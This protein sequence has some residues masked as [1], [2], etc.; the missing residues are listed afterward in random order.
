MLFRSSNN[1]SN[2]LTYY[3][4]NPSYYKEKS[5]NTVDHH[6]LRSVKLPSLIQNIKKNGAI[7][8][9]EPLSYRY[10]DELSDLVGNVDRILNGKSNHN[11][12]NHECIQVMLNIIKGDTTLHDCNKEMQ[13]KIDHAYK[14][15]KKVDE[16]ATNLKQS[17]KEKL[18]SEFHVILTYTHDGYVVGRAK[19]KY[20]ND[21][22]LDEKDWIEYTKPLHYVKSLDDYDKIDEIRPILIMRKLKLE[23]ENPDSVRKEYFSGED[24][25]DDELQI[26]SRRKDRWDS[27]DNFNHLALFI[28]KG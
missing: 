24:K 13:D 14:L 6:T 28:P 9:H 2:G 21:G 18:G 7:P 15:M 3:F 8:K 20:G 4:F 19:M 5:Q 16:D 11:L 12:H 23:N 10:I 27:F 17:L 22:K 26:I 25:Y 1:K